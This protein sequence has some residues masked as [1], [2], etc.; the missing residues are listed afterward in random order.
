VQI[1]L[2]KPLK[3]PSSNIDRKNVFEKKKILDMHGEVSAIVR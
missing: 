2:N 3:L 1:L